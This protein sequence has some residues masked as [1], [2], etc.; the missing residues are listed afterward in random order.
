M[1]N[2]QRRLSWKRFFIILLIVSAP[3]VLIGAWMK[4]THHNFADG[5]LTFGLLGDAVGVIGLI[6]NFNSSPR[7]PTGTPD[8]Q[9]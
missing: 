4:V 1:G 8:V 2:P 5:V 3:L 6:I 9:E 7:N